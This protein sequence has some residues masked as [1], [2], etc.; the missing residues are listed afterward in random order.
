MKY[1]TVWYPTIFHKELTPDKSPK[2]FRIDDGSEEHRYVCKLEYGEYVNAENIKK[3]CIK[4]TSETSEFPFS[5]TLYNLHV[6]RNGFATYYCDENDIPEVHRDLFFS[7]YLL[8]GP[9]YHKI[10]EFYHRHEAD[11]DKDSALIAFCSED[12]TEHKID[13]FDNKPLIRFLENFET[14]FRD[15]VQNISDRNSELEKKFNVDNAK[16]LIA[17]I[18]KIN[19]LCENAL[20]EYTFCKTL[21]TSIYNQSFI[22]DNNVQLLKEEDKELKIEYRRKA[23]N[24]RNAIRYIE[25]IKY[26]NQNRHNILVSDRGEQQQ[27]IGYLLAVWGILYAIIF[28]YRNDLQDSNWLNFRYW[29]ITSLLFISIICFIILILINSNFFKKVKSKLNS[30]INFPKRIKIKKSRD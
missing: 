17:S 1:I 25:S 5:L 15:Y 2:E 8:L 29:F 19:K 12:E 13:D 10:K 4:I 11:P 26:K 24:I 7:E 6:S 23:L 20:I 18:Y 22:H 21:L 27:R 3:H 28:V 30:V 9:I 16:S 14:M